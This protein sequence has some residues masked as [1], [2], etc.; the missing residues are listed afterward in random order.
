MNDLSF[1]YPSPP[2]PKPKRRYKKLRKMKEGTLNAKVL[3]YMENDAANENRG[4]TQEMAEKL[5]NG[6]NLASVIGYLEKRWGHRFYKSGRP[7]RYFYHGKGRQNPNFSHNAAVR[8]RTTTRLSPALN[9]TASK[10]KAETRLTN[11]EVRALIA[12][13]ASSDSGG[14]E[15]GNLLLKLAKMFSEKV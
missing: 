4:L 12:L 9:H 7:A 6:S 3:R 13:V 11:E 2:T 10:P 8:R 5:F 1:T 15:H 14:K